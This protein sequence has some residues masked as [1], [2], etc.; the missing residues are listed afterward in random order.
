MLDVP[1][2]VEVQEMPHRPKMD[3]PTPIEVAEGESRTVAQVPGMSVAEPPRRR[4]EMEADHNDPD[5]LGIGAMRGEVSRNLALINKFGMLN[6]FAAV[7]LSASGIGMTALWVSNQ[8]YVGQ[9]IK[10]QVEQNKHDRDDAKERDKLAR[11]DAKEAA[12]QHRE[13]RAKL[14]EAQRE[15]AA[16]IRDQTRAAEDTHLTMRK[17]LDMMSN[18][19]SVLDKILKKVQ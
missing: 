10:L 8:S 15:L 6:V 4:V 16:A 17:T 7:I 19:A 1:G 3:L 11:E 5:H 18:H 12:K 13:D 9:A 14:W 2:N